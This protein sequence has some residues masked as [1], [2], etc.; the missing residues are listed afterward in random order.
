MPW[1]PNCR[2]EYRE[3][4][5]TCSDCGSQLVMEIEPI[6]P[7]KEEQ[8]EYDQEALLVSVSDA[9]ADVIESLLQSYGIPV[10]RKYKE[11]GAFLNIY[12]GTS[13][14]GIDLYV[15]SKE[16]ERAKEILDNREQESTEELNESMDEIQEDEV[17]SRDYHKKR[18]I[19]IWI[20]LIIFIMPF[21]P[22]FFRLIMSAVSKLL[23]IK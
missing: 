10:M 16:L 21:I 17:I 8:I 5:N 20:I 11:A 14:Y 3:D 13:M 15:P 4:F 7:L 2:T 12:M 1:C 18:N 23:N 22:T 9:E 19:M 6:E